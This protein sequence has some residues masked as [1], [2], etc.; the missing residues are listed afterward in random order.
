MPL[1]SPRKGEALITQP[2]L[3]KPGL[4]PPPSTSVKLYILP[5]GDWGPEVLG[6]T[7]VGVLASL[8]VPKHDIY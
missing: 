1:R 8:T 5:Q 4:L 7:S 2:L 6:W 3:L